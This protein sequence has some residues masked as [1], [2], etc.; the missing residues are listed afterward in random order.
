[1]A[2]DIIPLEEFIELLQEKADEGD[3]YILKGDRVEGYQVKVNESKGVLQIG[4][5]GWAQE[6]FKDGDDARSLMDCSSLMDA[7]LLVEKEKLSQSAQEI[8]KQ[9]TLEDDIDE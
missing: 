3:Y 5:I 9:K 7:T 4:K 8:T 6:S 1:M 2:T